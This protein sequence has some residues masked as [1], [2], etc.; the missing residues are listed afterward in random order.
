MLFPII[1]RLHISLCICWSHKLTAP[2]TLHTVHCTLNLLY[3]EHCILF[4][5]HTAHCKLHTTYCILYTAHCTL[6]T[7]CCILYIL[8]MYRPHFT[9]HIDS[10][11][12][13]TS[14]HPHSSPINLPALASHC[15]TNYSRIILIKY[16]TDR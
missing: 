10:C 4:I 5:L 15:Q 7:T 2:N 9:L 3:T 8:N 11:L 16:S 13:N 12:A 1:C 6:H 14:T